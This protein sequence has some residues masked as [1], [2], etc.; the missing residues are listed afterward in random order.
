M[1]PADQ[2]E[3]ARVVTPQAAHQVQVATRDLILRQHANPGKSF[4]QLQARA[5]RAGA[6][7]RQVGDGAFMLLRGNT[8]AH[9]EDLDA[10]AALLARGCSAEEAS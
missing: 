5:A 3:A 10:V 4:E 1:N 6:V 7:L 2:K 9:A 8:S